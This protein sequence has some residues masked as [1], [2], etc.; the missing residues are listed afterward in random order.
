MTTSHHKAQFA[1]P[2]GA[3]GNQPVQVGE[4]QGDAHVLVLREMRARLTDAGSPARTAALDAAIA[5]LA[6]RQPGAHTFQAGVSEWMG[7]C[8]LPSLYSNMTERGDRL[9]EEVLELLQAHGYDQGRVS[10]LVDYVFGRPV[11][12]PAQEVGGVMVTLAGYCWVAGMDM[13]AAGDAEL[14]R[15]TQ[16]EVM[17]KI[18]RKQEAKNALHFDTPVPGD[19]AP[20]AQGIDLGRLW[21]QSH[22]A[23]L[24]HRKRNKHDCFVLRCLKEDVQKLIDSQRDAAPGVGNG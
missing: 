11:G 9:L 18:R 13:H 8:F 16:P 4:V 24:N 5:A 22:A 3:T 23:A 12:D 19:A 2:S 15:I 14:Q 10:T 21:E 6:A 7:Q 17:A 1:P 20:P